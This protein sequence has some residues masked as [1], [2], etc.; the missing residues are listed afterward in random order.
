[1]TRPECCD[2]DLWSIDAL[3]LD[4]T[5]A[6]AQA[7]ARVTWDPTADPA[8][9]A[10]HVASTIDQLS[11]DLIVA[12]ESRDLAAWSVSQA[13][14]LRRGA[15]M[16]GALGL[17]R[18]AWKKIRDRYA[19]DPP[20]ALVPDALAALPGLAAEAARINARLDAAL[21]VREAV[22]TRLAATGR[23][24][25]EIARLIGRDPSRVSRIRYRVKHAA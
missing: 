12:R 5:A 11:A 7:W 21:E 19:D 18:V 8:V 16:P 23:T 22:V 15:N 10:V 9:L 25:A 14:H 2:R 3:D 24:D 13:Y 6:E 1:M 20:A 17:K 4:A